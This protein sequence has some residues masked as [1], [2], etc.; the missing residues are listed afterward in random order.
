KKAILRG[1]R[2]AMSRARHRYFSRRPISED[3]LLWIARAGYAGRGAVFLLLGVFTGLAAL[4]LRWQPVGAL[5]SLVASS[6]GAVLVFVIAAGLF[7]FAFYRSIEAAWDIHNYGDDNKGVI[8]RLWLGFSRLFYA[9]FGIVAGSTVF[10]SDAND[11]DQTVRNWTAW[12]LGVPAG[13]WLVEIAGLVVVA[14]ELD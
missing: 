3:G 6:A 10:G 8:R 2:A 11:N 1:H 4:G 14:W 12:V 5:H 9:G 13:A 7:C